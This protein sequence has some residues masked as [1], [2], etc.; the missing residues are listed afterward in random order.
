M[1]VLR[2]VAVHNFSLAAG[3]PKEM[4]D[5]ILGF[6]FYDTVT[7]VHRAVHRANMAEVVERFTSAWL[8]R[9]NTPEMNDTREHWAINLER[10]DHE[11]DHEVQFQAVNCHVCG[12]YKETNVFRRAVIPLSIRC[13]CH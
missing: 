2:Q 13:R 1:S 6:C 3:L 4:A 5:E 10:L 7:A 9:A 12:N 8:S 11:E